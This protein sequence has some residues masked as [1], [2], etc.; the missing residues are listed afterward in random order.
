MNY[1][2]PF[3]LTLVSF[4]EWLLWCMTI[5]YVDDGATKLLMVLV[6][7]PSSAVT[8]IVISSELLAIFLSVLGILRRSTCVIIRSALS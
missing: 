1:Q 3:L 5:L 2:C 4:V 6:S 8:S 7:T